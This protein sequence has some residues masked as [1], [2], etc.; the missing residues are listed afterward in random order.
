VMFGA[1]MMRGAPVSVETLVYPLLDPADTSTAKG[2]ITVAHLLT[3]STGLA[4]DDNDDASPGNEDRMYNQTAQPDWY[5]FI[6]DLPVSHPAGQLYA[7]CSGGMNLVGGV[8]HAATGAWLPA[9]FD[10]TVAAPL[11]IRRWAMNLMP[12]GDGYGGGGLYLRPRDLLKLGVTYLDGGVWHGTRLVSADWARQSTAHQIEAGSG[13]SDG[14][15][16][17]R[18]TLRGAGGRSYQEYEASGNG[19]QLLIVVPEYDLVV[20][21][22]AANYQRYRIWRE[23][24]NDLVPNVIIP[25][26]QH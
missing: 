12:N 15:A 3:H 4:C 18:Y 2:R 23:F 26:I 13:S 1:A 8:V 20:V 24:R 5:H 21:Y 10:S 19:G 17:H 14:Y 16:W 22:T 6:L 25:A 7:Y 11:G 9:F